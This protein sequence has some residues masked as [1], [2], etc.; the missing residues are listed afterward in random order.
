MT[1]I[2]I[3]ALV[4]LLIGIV[5]GKFIFKANVQEQLQNARATEKQAEEKAKD[6]VAKAKIDADAYRKER[7]IDAKEHF[8]KLKEQHN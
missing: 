4:A 2:I 5:L 1:G 6:I 7:G 8:L 3:T